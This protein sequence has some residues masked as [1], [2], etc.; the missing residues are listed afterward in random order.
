MMVLADQK[1]E[2]SVSKPSSYKTRRMK[3]ST[4]AK[5]VEGSSNE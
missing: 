3:I 4:I 5:A 1:Y 2:N